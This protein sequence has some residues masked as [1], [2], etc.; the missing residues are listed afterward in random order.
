MI[1]TDPTI[2]RKGL[3]R[4]LVLAGL[5]HL[6]DRGLTVGM[7]YVDASNTPA[8]RLYETLGFRVH[9]VDRAYVTEV[10]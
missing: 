9:H 6:A 1:A 2:H 3:G 4:G 10:R 8:A 7:L 5:D